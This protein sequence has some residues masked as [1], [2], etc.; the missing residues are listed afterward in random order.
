MRLE[1]VA[2]KPISYFVAV[3]TYARYTLSRN[4]MH[5][6]PINRQA[7]DRPTGID[8][9]MMC[10]PVLAHMERLQISNVAVRDPISIRINP[11]TPPDAI[12]G[13]NCCK[14]SAAMPARELRT[15]QA[16]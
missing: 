1:W 15:M 9:W 11:A 14:L 7:S 6:K 16:A 8:R 4:R 3:K 2:Y 10:F 13:R 12:L 5:R